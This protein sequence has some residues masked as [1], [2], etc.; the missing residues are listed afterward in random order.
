LAVDA[1][2]NVY[3]ADEGNNSIRK[4]DPSGTVTTVAPNAMFAPRDVAVDGSGNLYVVDYDCHVTRIA[5]TGAAQ[6]VAGSI[7]G[8]ADGVGTAAKFG[9]P[10]G[11]ACD[12]Q[13]TIFVADPMDNVI[14]KVLPDGTVTT[15]A[16]L[17]GASG[18]VDGTGSAARFAGP[19]SITIDGQN[20]MFV[21]DTNGSNSTLRRITPA[22]EVTTVGGF[23]YWSITHAGSNRNAA[24]VAVATSGGSIFV[25]DDY[26]VVRQRTAAGALRIVAGG[27]GDQTA[28]AGPLP[29]HI[30]VPGGVAIL[31]SGQ[32]VISSLTAKCIFV[33]RSAVL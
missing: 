33:T 25:A 27:Y 1:M 9:F 10:R 17:A 24:V 30:G 31:P 15:F 20:N 12:S 2:G 6:I 3:V 5:G 19:A 7:S 14:R 22:A 26:N 11:I 29:A 13:G 16:G 18:S 32:L 4:V 8:Y 21:F 23:D 28:A